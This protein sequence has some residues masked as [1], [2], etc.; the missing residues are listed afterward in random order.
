MV[1]KKSKK[2]FLIIVVSTL[3]KITYIRNQTF[4]IVLISWD[5]SPISSIINN[6]ILFSKGQPYE[7]KNKGRDT[8][9]IVPSLPL[10]HIAAR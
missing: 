1:S 3:S 9:F 8:F 5:G 6:E 2:M 10:K 4:V 7:Q